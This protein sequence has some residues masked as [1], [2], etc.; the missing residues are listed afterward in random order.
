MAG[1]LLGVM[2]VA[3]LGAGTGAGTTAAAAGI[4]APPFPTPI[5]HV[6]VIFQEN[7]SFDN[8]LGKLC[9][10]E[11][12]CDGATS[13][14]LTNGTTIPLQRATDIVPNVAHST[15]AQQQAINGGKMN[16]F[17]Q[18]S[19]CS[20]GKNYQCYSQFD[21][22]QIPNVWHLAEQYAVSDRTFELDRILTFGAHVELAAANL[23]GF[24]GQIPN[25]PKYAPKSGPGWGCN[26]FKVTPWRASPQDPYQDV[27]PCIPWPDGTGSWWDVTGPSGTP[28]TSPVAHIPNIFDSLDA[29]QRSWKLYNT[30][31]AFDMCSYFAAC[32]QSEQKNNVAPSRKVI[33]DARAG[34]LANLN[35]VMPNKDK[36][37]G[38]MSQHNKFSMKAGDNWIGD[39]VSAVQSGPDWASTAIFITYDD[40]GC[41]YDHVPPPDSRTGIRLP[42]IIVSPYVKPGYTDSNNVSFVGMLAFSEHV[43]GLSSLGGDDAAS[44]DY[45]E[46]FD[47]NAPPHLAR[48]QMVTSK[49]SSK[50]KRY[51]RSVKVDLEDEDDVT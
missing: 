1:A 31:K 50:E 35:F 2:A 14:K 21:E 11:G 42:M 4:P 47:F 13:G 36:A 20:Q 25:R 8:V 28:Q 24:S 32:A 23:D 49:V 34:Q 45:F 18:I 38:D 15:G 48:T 27:P 12:R 30:T 41:F 7:H 19:G 39:V 46:A 9:V 16:G 10:Q 51:L 22:D 37:V 3:S 43:L 6:V 33:D 26:S 5:Q 17:Q 44:Y 40:C 29:G